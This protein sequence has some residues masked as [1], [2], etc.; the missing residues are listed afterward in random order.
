M[1]ENGER[2]VTS[3]R[4][5]LHFHV[6]HLSNQLPNTWRDY[7]TCLMRQKNANLKVKVWHLS[8]KNYLFITYLQSNVFCGAVEL[9]CVTLRA[10]SNT[11]QPIYISEGR[12]SEAD[13]LVWKKSCYIYQWTSYPQ[14]TATF[15]FWCDF[16]Y[17]VEIKTSKLTRISVMLFIFFLLSSEAGQTAAAPGCVCSNFYEFFCVYVQ[18]A[19]PRSPVRLW[20]VLRV[21]DFWSG[22][23][24][25]WGGGL[26][27]ALG[28][29]SSC[30]ALTRGASQRRVDH[31]ESVS[32]LRPSLCHHLRW[33]EGVATPTRLLIKR[34]MRQS[35]GWAV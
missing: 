19:D 17:H 31:Q 5:S 6:S 9:Y 14:L 12:L 32:A 27:S 20:W 15:I 4:T 2:C 3:S 21:V 10:V 26:V 33:M 23:V 30:G 25:F 28:P 8:L 35:Q 34:L 13:L 16:W 1:T 11:F 22:F 18:P 7:I 24:F 29:C